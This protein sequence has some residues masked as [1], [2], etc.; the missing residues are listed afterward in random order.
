MASQGTNGGTVKALWRY[1]VKSMAGNK[2]DEAWV[3]EGGILGDRAYAVIDGT[4]GR[5]GSAKTPRKWATLMTLAADFVSPPEAGAPLPPVRIVWPDGTEATSDGG[6]ADARLSRTLGRPVTLTAERPETP[7]LERLDPLADEETIVDIGDL[8][9]AGR[10]SDYAALHLITTA[11]MARLAAF[12]PESRFAARRFRPNVTIA[13]PDGET[14]FVENDWVGRE[15]AIRRRGAAPHLRSHAPL[16]GPD[17]RA[18]GHGEGP[19]RAAHHRRAQPPSCPAARRRIAAMRRRLRLRHSGRNRE[20]RRRG[21]GDLGRG[22]RPSS[23]SPEP[24]FF[25]SMGWP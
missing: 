21:K 1:P 5:V 18:E 20:E 11:T 19:A 24:C 9:M 10:F 8:M 17:H 4:S 15:L 16:L 13:T 25:S 2:L 14:G 7:S 22:R 3:T 23:Q 6:D 12:R